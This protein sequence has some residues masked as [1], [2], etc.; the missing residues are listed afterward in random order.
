LGV[1]ERSG[2]WEEMNIE[3]REASGIAEVMSGERETVSWAMSWRRWRVDGV[4]DVKYRLKRQS[5]K[6]H[7]L[8]LTST[9]LN[10]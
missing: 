7:P 6:S 8:R 9:N 1:P 10:I 3:E 5:R 2:S 4:I